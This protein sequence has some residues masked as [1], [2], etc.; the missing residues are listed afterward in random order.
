VEEEGY[1]YSVDVLRGKT[2]GGA[3]VDVSYQ[4]WLK[5]ASGDH[6]K[7]GAMQGVSGREEEGSW[8]GVKPRREAV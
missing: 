5:G 3:R 2:A 8:R 7:L 6:P 4:H 1:V